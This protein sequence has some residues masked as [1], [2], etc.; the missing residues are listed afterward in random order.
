MHF[1][2]ASNQHGLKHNPFKALVAPRPVGWI[3]TRAGD[4]TR[5]L[6]PYSF[7]NAISDRPP[8]V[9]FSSGGMKDTLRNVLASGEFTCSMATWDL[10]EAMNMSSAAVASG[11]DEFELAGLTAADSPYGRAPFVAEAPAALICQLWQ[12]LELPAH[13]DGE[14]SSY[15]LV[16][17]RVVGIHIRDELIVDGLVP[18]AQLRPL[19]RMGYMDF[20]VVTPENTFTMNRPL[21]TADGQ[22]ATLQP[23]AW[24]GIYR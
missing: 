22:S 4:G 11:V 17:G 21:A 3:G 6:A 7:F 2:T 10:R 24:D 18:T 13:R 19:A 5:N 12:T 15:T 23:G 1:D 9:M 14:P 8:M 20:S 16:M